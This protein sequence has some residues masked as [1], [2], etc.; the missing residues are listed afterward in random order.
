MDKEVFW[1]RNQ[2]TDSQ[3]AGILKQRDDEKKQLEEMGKKIEI[4]ELKLDLAAKTFEILS[5]S[6]KQYA[7]LNNLI[8]KTS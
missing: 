5:S 7:E 3:I 6:T 4:L 1:I 8:D 2:A